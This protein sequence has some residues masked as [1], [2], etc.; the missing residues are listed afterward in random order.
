MAIAPVPHAPAFV[1]GL[2]VVRGSPVPVVDAG[3]LLGLPGMEPGRWVA[4]RVGERSIV[5][6][7]EAVEGV[8]D[9]PV[10]SAGVLPPL[11]SSTGADFV[12]AVGTLDAA[13]LWVLEAVRIVPESVWQ[14]IAP[15]AL[16]R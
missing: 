14:A 5:M 4:L 3:R 9:F 8:R 1:Q 6:A 11:L 16:A 2:A 10:T 7:V 15:Q 13:L 12:A